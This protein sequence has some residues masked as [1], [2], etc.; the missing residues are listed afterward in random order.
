MR[1]LKKKKKGVVVV[2]IGGVEEGMDFTGGS[3]ITAA[4]ASFV[5]IKP[6]N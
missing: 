2:V 6:R 5:R 3:E 1:A 4:I